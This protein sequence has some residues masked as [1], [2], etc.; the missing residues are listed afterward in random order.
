MKY[1]DIKKIKKSKIILVYVVII[2]YLY[3]TEIKGLPLRQ[4]RKSGLRP[5]L[6]SDFKGNFLHTW[7]LGRLESTL[8]EFSKLE[9]VSL[10]FLQFKDSEL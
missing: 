6:K 1:L 5:T 7:V 8:C 4:G 3:N 10:S 9:P 2:P